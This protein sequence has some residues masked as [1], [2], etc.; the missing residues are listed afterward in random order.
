MQLV[1]TPITDF[2]SIREL[3][4][5]LIDIFDVHQ[6][7]VIQFCILHRDI[8][9][10][11]IMMYIIDTL[12][13]TSKDTGVGAPTNDD[14]HSDLPGDENV[15]AEE[16]T[17]EQ[18]LAQWE[19][20]RRQRIQAGEMRHGILIDFDYMT[21]IQ[22]GQSNPVGTG[23]RT[24]TI[25]FMSVN[26]LLNYK[27][28]NV[29]HSANDNLESLIYVLIWI[30][31]LYAGPKTLRQDK[32][33]METILKTWVLVCNPNNAVTLGI[34]KIGLR[35]Q[36][37]TITDDFTKFFKPLS[38]VVEKLLM[39]VRTTWSTTDTLHNYKTIRDILLEG[40]GMVEE[41]P[42]WSPAKDTHGY[43]LLKTAGKKRKI[44]SYSGSNNCP[45]VCMFCTKLDN[46]RYDLN[47]ILTYE[48]ME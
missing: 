39:A 46:L 5:I 33:T 38:P 7:L 19:Q 3:L 30:C 8:S 32:D 12:Q 10:N 14:H 45:N 31:V 23:D 15:V 4:S 36:P 17:H 47:P 35:S 13:N 43:G 16:E 25:P 2:T 48:C 9:L 41:V 27:K 34:H 37:S 24:G 28:L 6:K 11:N 1:A 18:K 22:P 44:P 40:F 29:V 42:N 26:M 21:T 20:E